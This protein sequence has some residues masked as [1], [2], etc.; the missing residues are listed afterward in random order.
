M[1][2]TTGSATAEPTSPKAPQ[3][4]TNPDGRL[5]WVSP[6]LPGRAHDLTAVRAPRIIRICERQGI[7]ILTDRTYIGA[8]PWV[9]TEASP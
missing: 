9:T 4:V 8:G 5:L 1:N 6:A 3:V 2:N 7:P